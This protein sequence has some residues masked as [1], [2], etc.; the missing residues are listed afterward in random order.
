MKNSGILKMS[1]VTGKCPQ[2]LYSNKNKIVIGDD[3]GSDC[4]ALGSQSPVCLVM[5]MA[6]PSTES[7]YSECCTD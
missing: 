6:T 1:N 3:G 2:A 7:S 4:P 5:V